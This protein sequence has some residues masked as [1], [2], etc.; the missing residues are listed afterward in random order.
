MSHRTTEA[1][2]GLFEELTRIAPNLNPTEIMSDYEDAER[3]SCKKAFPNARI[4]GCYFH[5]AQVSI[6]Y[7]ALKM[8]KPLL[9]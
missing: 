2:D 1:Y 4:L 6:K 9:Y 7:N 3:N 8:F 5:Y